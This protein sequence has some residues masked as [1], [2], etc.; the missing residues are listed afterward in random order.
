[1]DLETCCNLEYHLQKSDSIQ[2]RTSAPKLHTRAPHLTITILGFLIAAQFRRW[3]RRWRRQESQ[4]CGDSSPGRHCARGRGLPL[5]AESKEEGGC[6]VVEFHSKACAS[7]RVQPSGG[8]F[9][10]RT[11]PAARADTRRCPHR[12]LLRI[13]TIVQYFHIFRVAFGGS[14]PPLYHDN[15]WRVPGA[16]APSAN[17]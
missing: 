3:R 5:S 4:P 8:Q 9:V 16:D 2:P 6:C 17:L 1:M 7:T 10:M 11:L 13:K 12:L 15:S 14:R